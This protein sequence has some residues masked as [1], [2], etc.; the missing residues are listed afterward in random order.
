MNGEIL[1]R[2]RKKYSKPLHPWEKTRM[3]A[4]D[5]LLR[6]YGLRRKKEIWKTATILRN[7][8]RQA[9]RLLAMTGKQAELETKQLLERLRKLGLIREGA[10][11]DDVLGLTLEDLLERRLQTMVY[12]KGLAQTPRQ[13]RQM[14][15]HGHITVSG[16]RVNVPS[17]LVSV[18]EEKEIGCVFPT[19]GERSESE[20]SE[21]SGGDQG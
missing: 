3:D 1:K 21:K 11:L 5:A 13:A 6:K 15:I 12:R 16:N 19:S 7:W 4:E 8:R 2:Q 20:R 10:T 9:R 17:Y 18:N 14:V